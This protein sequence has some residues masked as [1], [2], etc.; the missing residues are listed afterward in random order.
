MP[1]VSNAHG[2]ESLLCENPKRIYQVEVSLQ[3]Q[4]NLD[5]LNSLLQLELLL[6]HIEDVIVNPTKTILQGTLPEV[7]YYWRALPPLV[8]PIITSLTVFSKLTPYHHILVI[9]SCGSLAMSSAILKSIA[10]RRQERISATAASHSL[11]TLEL[12]LLASLCAHSALMVHV[13]RW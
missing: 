9:P 6:Q 4:L 1:Q 11:T 12:H 7:T 13:L 2:V 8:I 3:A 5:L 10:L